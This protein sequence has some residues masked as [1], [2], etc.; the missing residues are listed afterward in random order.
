MITDQSKVDRARL[1]LS[2]SADMLGG[3][4]HALGQSKPQKKRAAP[5]G[6]PKLST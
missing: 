1:S 3:D 6:G 4:T 5:K 2:L